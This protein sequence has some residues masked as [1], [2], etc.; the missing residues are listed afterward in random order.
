L[1]W[2]Q[3]EARGAAVPVWRAGM[4]NGIFSQSDIL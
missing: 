2:L 4:N 1:L 3:G